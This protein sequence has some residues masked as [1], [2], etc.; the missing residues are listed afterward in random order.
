MSLI[1]QFF[2]NIPFFL[3]FVS[4]TFTLKA[5]SASN[6]IFQLSTYSLATDELAIDELTF[7]VE[8]SC[9][10]FRYEASF[11]VDC[12]N[13]PVFIVI[14]FI[15]IIFI[16]AYAIILLSLIFVALIAIVVLLKKVW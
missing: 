11:T 12:F 7:V 1:V 5:V 14:F 9:F 15:T 2:S 13:R 4:F 6:F 10:N 8:F 16:K 3:L